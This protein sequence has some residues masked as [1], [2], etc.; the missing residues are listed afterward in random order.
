MRD[1]GDDALH[2]DTHDPGEFCVVLQLHL[3]DVVDLALERLLP[4]VVLDHANAR[5]HL[6]HKLHARVRLLQHPHTHGLR[7]RHARRLN[8]DHEDV[9]ADGDPRERPQLLDTVD[10]AD[11][12]LGVI[13]RDEEHHH[14]DHHKEVRQLDELEQHVGVRR[15]DVHQLTRRG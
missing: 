6:V 5:Q 3:A 15:H 9:D 1:Q 10:D 4:T 8:Q 12:Q 14:G 13:R 11:D 7:S 2:A